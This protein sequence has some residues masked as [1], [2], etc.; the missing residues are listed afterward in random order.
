MVAQHQAMDEES[1][2]RTV[3]NLIRTLSPKIGVQMLP[4]DV[5]VVTRRPPKP[6][7]ADPIGPSGTKVSTTTGGITEAD[8]WMRLAEGL[9]PAYD[10]PQPSEAATHQPAAAPAYVMALAGW[11][12]LPLLR[13]CGRYASAPL[14]IYL[15]ESEFDPSELLI[16]PFSQTV[17]E[18]GELGGN[19]GH[20]KIRR[21][22]IGLRKKARKTAPT[23]LTLRAA[24]RPVYTLTL[25]LT[26]HHHNIIADTRGT[27]RTEQWRKTVT[28]S[29]P[30]RTATS[31]DPS[32]PDRTPAT[33]LAATAVPRAQ[34]DDEEELELNYEDNDGAMEVDT[35]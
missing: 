27:G 22:A 6:A 13:Y 19:T 26:A 30:E 33:A 8:M 5:R 25:Q 20:N 23:S 3:T 35:D 12:S 4:T 11:P 24:G 9:L 16:H 10:Q 29:A 21:A 17:R 31:S 32:S 28:T 1:R 34:A 15:T 18:A 7:A 2:G 14:V